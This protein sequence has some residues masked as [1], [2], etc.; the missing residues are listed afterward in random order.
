MYARHVYQ[1]YVDLVI[2][3][4]WHVTQR[5]KWPT[6]VF[7]EH[8]LAHFCKIPYLKTLLE[9]VDTVYKNKHNKENTDCFFIL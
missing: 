1:I 3:S 8:V 6:L 7:T 9:I 2:H 5:F 4:Y